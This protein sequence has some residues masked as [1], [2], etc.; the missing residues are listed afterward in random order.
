MRVSH[1]EI[2][3]CEH[4]HLHDQIEPGEVDETGDVERDGTSVERED[5]CPF[6][7]RKAELAELVAKLLWYVFRVAILFL[8]RLFESLELRRLLLLTPCVVDV[9][10]QEKLVN[11]ISL[12][13]CFP[14][15]LLLLDRV[16]EFTA[17]FPLQ[18]EEMNLQ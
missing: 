13:R 6:H 8:E 9:G 14:I 12:P 17:S 11:D 4:R 3:G 18:E 10:E 15:D 16:V 2:K 5:V 1:I 7:Q